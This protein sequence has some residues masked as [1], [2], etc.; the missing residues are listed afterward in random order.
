VA[1]FSIAVSAALFVLAPTSASAMTSPGGDLSQR[2]DLLASP[3][4]RSAPDAV[5]AA[6]LGVSRQGPG[7][8][9][10][11]GNR[12][13]AYVRF[14]RGAVSGAR[15]LRARGAKVVHV[16]RRYQRVTVAAKPTQLRG[17]GRA[18]RV[19][20]VTEAL[21]PVA[22][23]P[24][25]PGSVVSEGV[26]QMKAGLEPEEA[27]ALYPLDG[28]GVT[29]GVLSDSFDLA[30]EAADGSGPVA[31]KAAEDVASEDLPG[32][33]GEEVP[34]NVLDEEDEEVAEEEPPA[35]EGRAMAQIVHDVAPGADIAFASAFNGEDVFAANI[36]A[37]AG[38]GA[39]VIVDDVFYYEE[40]FFQDGPVAVAATEAVEGG[41][42]YL[43]AAGNNNLFDAEG[44]EIA[45]WETPTYRDA[46]SCPPEVSALPGFKGFHCLDF[47][48]A[49]A[50]VD[51][52]F[53]IKVAAGATLTVDL[54]WDEPWNGVETDLDA[55]LLNAAGDLIAGSAE[56]NE[57][58]QRPYELIQWENPS[59]SERTV[60]LVVNRFSGANP[61]LKFAI[62]ANGSGVEAT[63]YPRSSGPDVVGPTIFGHS[64]TD[65]AI[66]VGAIHFSGSA[67]PEAYSSRGP[68]RHGHGP[69]TGT[70]AAAPLGPNEILSK[71][72]LIATDCGATTFFAGF[73]GSA[74]RF[75]GTSAAAPHAAGV[76]ALML[77]A[78]AEAETPPTPAE[79]RTALQAGAAPVGV[80]PEPCAVGAGLVDAVGALEALPSIEPFTPPECQLPAPVPPEEARASGDWGSEGP[81]PTPPTTTPVPEPGPA[82][83]GLPNQVVTPRT[84]FHHR[85]PHLIRTRTLRAKAVFRFGSNLAGVSFYCRV[86]G[87]LLRVCPSRLAQRYTIG[88]H[89][90]RV[91]ARDAATGAFD[92]TP[93]VYRFRVK[94]V[95]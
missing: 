23:A 7:S 22:S 41:A 67:E 62:L 18:P 29:V 81:P 90:V 20:A 88:R 86:D 4:L 30:T 46:E 42:T 60:Q 76:A 89:V 26:E 1:R 51:R 16:S 77:E 56:E 52:T 59:S 45:S 8:L 50:Q 82:P 10:R 44:N 13:L 28:S 33:C 73:T 15:A 92:R 95:R 27:R 31:T 5:Q 64:G 65:S 58:S 6:R 24:C 11:Q 12:V 14:D 48:P 71:P 25:T 19:A 9:L 35:D 43:S 32:A 61:R 34:V 80:E 91:F 78:E 40:P 36:G 54:Q 75:C 37:L 21:A 94:P 70:E 57:L 55:F 79:I 83:A 17:I 69:V 2:L 66:S 39:D 72:D 85:P 49:K 68:V 3:G 74:W 38:A 63:E 87:G 84:F 93:A 47:A 53:G